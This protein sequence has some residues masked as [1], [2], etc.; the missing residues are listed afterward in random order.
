MSLLVSNCSHQK[1]LSAGMEAVNAPLADFT[2][3][4]NSVARGTGGS[5]VVS[6]VSESAVCSSRK[7]L[8]SPSANPLPVTRD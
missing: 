4:A 5:E 2:V 3:F 7:W 6:V 1:R 8:T